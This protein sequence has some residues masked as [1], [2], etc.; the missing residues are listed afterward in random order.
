[1]NWQLSN[2]LRAIAITLVIWIHASHP[3]WFGAHGTVSLDSLN[4]EVFIDTAINQVGR[5]TVPLFVILSGFGLAKSEQSRPFQLWGF[6]QRRGFRILPP[7]LFFTLLNLAF[8]QEFQL[9]NWVEKLGQI[10]IALRDGSGDYHLYFLTI[11]IQCY[12]SYPLLRRIPFTGWNLAIAAVF[13]LSMFTLRWAVSLFHWLPDL[14]PY[15]PNSNHWMFWLPYFLFGIWLA[16]VPDWFTEALQRCSTQVWGCL[17]AIAAALELGEFYFSAIRIGSAEAVGHYGRPTVVLLTITFLLW[18]MSWK[19]Q[20]EPDS[21][22]RF[23][24]FNTLIERLGNASF[25]TYLLHTQVLRLI[26]PTQVL[27]GIGY[28]LIAAIASWAIGLLVW[29]IVKPVKGLNVI[30]GA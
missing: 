27:G 9:G 5:F 17:W 11:I 30:F 25:T 29:A 22:P 19:P 18:A 24:Q 15:L 12:I 10:A 1:M 26:T 8:R 2:L 16:K 28:L 20:N 21:P 13:T 3:W 7:Y 4:W 6:I 14:A 23:P